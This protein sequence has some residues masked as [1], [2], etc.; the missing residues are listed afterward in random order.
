MWSAS[1]GSR[2]KKSVKFVRRE[3]GRKERKDGRKRNFILADIRHARDVDCVERDL[4]VPHP[5]DGLRHI[6]SGRSESMGDE[7]D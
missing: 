2:S 6:S 7:V 1:G 3:S 4:K 5:Q